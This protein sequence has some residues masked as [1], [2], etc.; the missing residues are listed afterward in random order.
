[1]PVTLSSTTIILILTSPE[2]DFTKFAVTSAV[3]LRV[4]ASYLTFVISTP[5]SAGSAICWRTK[6]DQRERLTPTVC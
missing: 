2:T 1:M 3:I 6:F 5:T 4:A